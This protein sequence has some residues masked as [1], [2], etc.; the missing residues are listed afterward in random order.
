MS[1]KNFKK[2]FKKNTDT[3]I[4]EIEKITKEKEQEILKV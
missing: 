3:S 4:K 2:M 1:Q